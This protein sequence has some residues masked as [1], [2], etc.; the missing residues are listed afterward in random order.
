MIYQQILI[1]QGREENVRE[2]LD[3]NASIDL[4]TW[5]KHS[6][7]SKYWGNIQLRD[8]KAIPRRSK[9]Q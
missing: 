1:P 8:I 2:P 9:S 7:R 6:W 4:K 5:I 3:E